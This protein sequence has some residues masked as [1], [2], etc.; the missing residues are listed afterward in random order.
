[1]RIIAGA[2]KGR[3]LKTVS[4]PGYRPAMGRVRESLFSRLESRGVV[5]GECRVLDLFAGSGSL[6]FEALSRGAAEAVFV[7][8]NPRAAACLAQNA[9]NLGAESRCRILT[10]DVLRVSAR[11]PALP[12]QVIFI[13]PPYAEALFAPAL[14]NILRL[15]WLAEDGF[16]IAE[17]E[18][19]LRFDAE[20][21]P[22][23][24][25]LNDELYGQTRVILWTAGHD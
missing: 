16:L 14:R 6:A 23:L 2:Y 12:F 24:E 25:L 13:D 15:N 10:E 5:W 11:R 4:G 20:K 3:I 9:A 21:Q 19:S 7:E 8:K 1:M 22:G 18:K 17:V